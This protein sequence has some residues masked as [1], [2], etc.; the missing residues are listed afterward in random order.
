MDTVIVV[1]P[2]F[3]DVTVYTFDESRDALDYAKGK[4]LKVLDLAK[5]NAIRENVEN[6]LKSNPKAMLYH[7]DH[8]NENCIWGNDNRAVVDLNNVDLLSGRESYNDNC[9][10]A[11]ELGVEAWKRGCLAYWGYIDVFTFTTDA[12]E[13]FKEAIN[14]GFKRR[15]DGLAWKDCLDKAK[16]RMTEIIDSLVASGRGMA[17]SCLTHDRDCLVCYTPDNAP[18]EPSCPV[19]QFILGLFGMKTLHFLRGIRN[20]IAMI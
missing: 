10:S 6:A 3:D 15:L 4:G 11:K 14:F 12:A 2:L 9:S 13:E 16:Q 19:S 5:E 20:S 17:A 18:T 7:A 8:G 1:A